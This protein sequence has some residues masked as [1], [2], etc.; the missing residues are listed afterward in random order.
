MEV[1][2]VILASLMTKL[3]RRSVKGHCSSLHSEP[4]RYISR[5]QRT[6]GPRILVLPSALQP[7]FPAAS[8]NFMRFSLQVWRIHI[9][10]RCGDRMNYRAFTSDFCVLVIAVAHWPPHTNIV[11]TQLGPCSRRSRFHASRDFRGSMFPLQ[12]NSTRDRTWLEIRVKLVLKS[13]TTRNQAPPIKHHH[14]Y[15]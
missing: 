11:I 9:R 5:I 7:G 2:I 4:C 13:D 6:H 8:A 1:V 15:S 12:T 14:I 10:G 3:F